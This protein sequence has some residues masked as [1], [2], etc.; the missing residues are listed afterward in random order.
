M[1]NTRQKLFALLIFCKNHSLILNEYEGNKFN[2]YD[3][4]KSISFTSIKFYLIKQR[5]NRQKYTKL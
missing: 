5:K 4:K 1:K 3:E 2:E